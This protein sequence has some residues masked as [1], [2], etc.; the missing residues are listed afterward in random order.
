VFPDWYKPYML[1]YQSEGY[2][3]LALGVFTVFGYSYLNDIK[4]QKGRKSR[5]VW[6]RS[7]LTQAK[8]VKQQYAKERLAAGDPQFTKFLEKKERHYVNAHH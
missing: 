8:L 6:E 1:N 2:F 4:E 3:L 7:D 5:K